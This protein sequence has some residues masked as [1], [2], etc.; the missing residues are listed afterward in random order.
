[1]NRIIRLAFF[2]AVLVLA[3]AS[4]ALA[5]G[6]V[7]TRIEGEASVVRQGQTLPATEGMTL[8]KDDTIIA[9][10]GGGVDVNLNDQA[11]VRLLAASEGVLD[12][13]GAAM[14]VRVTSGNAIMNLKKLP[15]GTTFELETPTAIAAVRGTQFWGRVDLTS[16]DN[17][18]TTFAVREGSVEV[19]AKSTSEKFTL[20]PGQAL[21]IPK[22]AATAPSVREA[23]TEEMNAMEQASSIKTSA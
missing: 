23:L 4:S 15:V 16:A 2:S 13:T 20:S 9:P 12:G 8:Q 21:D 5:E 17:P 6:T 19:L 18:V 7:I 10:A 22:D 11:G 1:M 14:K 3:G